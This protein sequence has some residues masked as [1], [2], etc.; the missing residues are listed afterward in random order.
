MA[1]KNIKTIMKKSDRSYVI[2]RCT[3]SI[4]DPNYWKLVKG[5][6]KE[7]SDYTSILIEQDFH[8]DLD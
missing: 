3:K 7:P 4:D 1:G 2:A 6:Y 8:H 5:H